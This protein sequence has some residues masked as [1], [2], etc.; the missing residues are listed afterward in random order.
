LES[1]PLTQGEQRITNAGF[2]AGGLQGGLIAA[3]VLGLLK[4][5][6]APRKS[7]EQRERKRVIE[8]YRKRIRREQL[9]AFVS[10]MVIVGA[11]ATIFALG[12]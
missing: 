9:R 1:A 2:L 7:P 8:S 6:T 5:A 10:A 3:G 11:C 4:A 12:A